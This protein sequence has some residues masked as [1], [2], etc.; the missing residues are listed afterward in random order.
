MKIFQVKAAVEEP[1]V[2]DAPPSVTAEGGPVH[3][4]GGSR[5][6]LGTG[7]LTIGEGSKLCFARKQGE[8]GTWCRLGEEHYGLPSPERKGLVAFDLR[9]PHDGSAGAGDAAINDDDA[10]SP[11]AASRRSQPKPPED[12]GHGDAG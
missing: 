4:P 2:V 1:K 7:V 6:G 10:L 9:A 3:S 11:G 12:K 5:R 8:G